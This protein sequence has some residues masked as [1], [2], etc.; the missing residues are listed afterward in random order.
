MGII[1]RDVKPDDILL[2]E[3]GDPALTDLGIAGARVDSRRSRVC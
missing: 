1:H 3:Y 2:T